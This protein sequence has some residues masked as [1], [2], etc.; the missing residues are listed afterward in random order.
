MDRVRTGTGI[1]DSIWPLQSSLLVL[2][3][4]GVFLS[5]LIDSSFFPLPL[6]TDLLLMNLCSQH[7]VRTPYYVVLATIGSLA[8]CVWVY[9]LA[10]KGGEIY[11]RKG[12]ALPQRARL[13]MRRYPLASVFFPALAPFPVPFKPFV[14]AQGIFG[15]P[16]LTFL[17]GTLLGRGCRFLIEGLLGARYGAAAKQFVLTQKWPSAAVALG[18]AA[19][20]FLIY[21]WPKLR[22]A[23]SDHVR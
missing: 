11:S 2:G 16:W 22:R 9:W 21:Q 1:V 3:G 19:V 8:G 13:F 10:R 17:L 20:I 5:S 18:L 14:V 12:R 6:V 7:P 4:F 15:V 23:P